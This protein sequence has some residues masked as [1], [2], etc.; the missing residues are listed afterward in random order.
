M[1]WNA[2]GRTVTE[3]QRKFGVKRVEELQQGSSEVRL[4][5]VAVKN[6]D[7]AE[8]YD[9]EKGTTS[10]PTDGWYV[11]EFMLKPVADTR[12]GAV[13]IDCETANDAQILDVEFNTSANAHSMEQGYV[14]SDAKWNRELPNKTHWFARMEL[15]SP[16]DIWFNMITNTDSGEM[17]CRY[18]LEQG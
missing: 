17:T 15:V 11:T 9:I 6:A 7:K 14:F 8:I 13:D 18:R 10:R 5:A 16:D 2:F 4:H 12:A 1:Q 3:S